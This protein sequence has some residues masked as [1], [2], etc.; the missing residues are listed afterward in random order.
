MDRPSSSTRTMSSWAGGVTLP[1]SLTAAGRAGTAPLAL[2]HVLE[3]LLAPAAPAQRR[4]GGGPEL[5]D[6]LGVRRAA[7]RAGDRSAWLP[8]VE[9][10]GPGRPR[11]GGARRRDPD[12]CELPPA[13]GGDR[14]GGPRR[15]DDRAVVLGPDVAQHPEIG[16]RQDGQLGID[17]GPGDHPGIDARVRRPPS[18]APQRAP[19]QHVD[20]G[21]TGTARA[22]GGSIDNAAPL[23]QLP[24]NW[25]GNSTLF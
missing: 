6:L 16:Q 18:A 4:A 15:V 2:L 10:H 1:S 11:G 9:R 24:T 22:R 3:G 14:V 5:A 17:D 23:R 12:L 8:E 21:R 19:A 7:Q 13:L 25:S 20:P